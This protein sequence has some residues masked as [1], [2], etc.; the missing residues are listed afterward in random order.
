MPSTD[1]STTRFSNRVAD[2]IRY[3]PGYPP[4]LVQTLQTEA[5]LNPASVVADI[6][7]GTGISSELFLMLG[8]HVYAV[9]PNAEMR[10]AAESRF[11][12]DPRFRSVNATAEQTTLPESSVDLVAAGQAFH[13]FDIDRTRKEFLRILRPDG[14]VALFWNSRRTSTTPFLIGYE[15]LLLEFATDYEQINHTNI[16]AAVLSKV[17]GGTNFQIRKYPTFQDFDWEGLRGRLLSSSYAPAAGH[18]RHEPML[19]ELSR[20][21]REHQSSGTV[22]FEY[23]TELYFGRLH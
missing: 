7:S 1:D 6:G 18:P 14:F 12:N 20:L 13:W 11:A 2:Y 10:A 16:D 17:F 15:K 8:C 21:F 3:R 19:L 23:D 5:G 9:E 22:R 4:E